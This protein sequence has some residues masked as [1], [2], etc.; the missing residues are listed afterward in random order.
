MGKK[1]IPHNAPQKRGPKAGFNP[2]QHSFLKSYIPEYLHL[3]PSKKYDDLWAACHTT[4]HEQWPLPEL[5][6]EEIADGLTMQKK[7]AN[8]KQVWV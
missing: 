6:E 1:K 7:T 3:Q 4:F 8:Q 5:T 2:E